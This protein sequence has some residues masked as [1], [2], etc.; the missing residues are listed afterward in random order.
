M[1]STSRL[2]FAS[3]SRIPLSNEL[4]RVRHDMIRPVLC[5][6]ACAI[7]VGSTIGVSS[8]ALTD[9]ARQRVLATDAR[10]V[11]ALLHG[12]GAALRQIYADDYT[13]VTQTGAIRTK[14]DQLRELDS[15][16]IR[17]RHVD[18]EDQRVR[19]YGDV[20]IVL[21]R[22]HTVITRDGR[23]VGGDLRFT[24]VYKLFGHTWRL[25]ASH[26]SAVTP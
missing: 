12:N 1:R 23:D 15:G 24:R 18:V 11:D 16:A 22:D 25:I 7:V 17:Y 5:V 21:S 20:A 13:L 6:I 4:R 19:V 2:R 26:A 8:K 10:R 9:T 3:R 14:S